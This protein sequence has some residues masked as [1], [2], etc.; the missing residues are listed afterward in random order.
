MPL[1]PTGTI[2]LTNGQILGSIRL[3]Y[4]FEFIL[5]SAAP[6]DVEIIGENSQ[7]SDYAWFSPDPATLTQGSTSVTVTAT[8]ATNA[9][10]PWF[11]YR[12]SGMTGAQNV[13]VVVSATMAVPK[14]S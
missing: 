12:L 4:P 9:Q 6:N 7:G 11:T 8:A 13:H 3:N 2:N 1:N 5:G 10:N 14:A